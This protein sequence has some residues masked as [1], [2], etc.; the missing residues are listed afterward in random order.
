MRRQH[1]NI[2][3]KLTKLHDDHSNLFAEDPAQKETSSSP[4]S[5]RLNR[6][7]LSRSLARL[8]ARASGDVQLT[9]SLIDGPV[10][11]PVFPARMSVGAPGVANR[12]R[13]D[14]SLPA[15]CRQLASSLGTSNG[16]GEV[17]LC[18]KQRPELVATIERVGN[19][20]GSRV[21]PE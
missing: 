12:I 7:I 2:P 21:P 19:P 10:E 11:R 6:R 15:H 3:E 4:I 1:E 20:S 8:V 17:H 16:R 13:S 5:S 9:L 18:L 14:G